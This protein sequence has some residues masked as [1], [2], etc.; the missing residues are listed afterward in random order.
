MLQKPIFFHLGY[1]SRISE[2]ER[3]LEFFSDKDVKKSLNYYFYPI[4]ID[5]EQY[6]E[7]VF[8]AEDILSINH[9]A[10]KIPANIIFLP[11]FRPV[12]AFSE[13]EKEEFNIIIDNFLTAFDQKLD[14]LEVL[15]ETTT[16]MVEN[17]GGIERVGRPEIGSDKLLKKA[18]SY[19]VSRLYEKDEYYSNH[20]FT[21]STSSLRFLLEYIDYTKD[22]TIERFTRSIY[23]RVHNSA[24]I[25][26]ID[27][28][29]FSETKDIYCNIPLYEKSAYNNIQI[30]MLLAESYK[31]MGWKRF[32]IIAEK[33][34]GFLERE[35]KAPDG[36]YYTYS[37][38]STRCEDS[39]YYQFTKRDIHTLFPDSYEKIITSLGMDISLPSNR[40]QIPKNSY[41]AEQLTEDELDL[42]RARRKKNPGMLRDERQFAYI[43]ALVIRSYLV[44]F[45]I[46]GKKEY[47]ET[48]LATRK[49]LRDKFMEG[50]KVFRIRTDSI[51]KVDGGL[52]DY[53]QVIRADID[54]YRTLQKREYLNDAIDI[55][56]YV[57]ENFYKEENGM[58][59]AESKG[60]NLVPYN[61]E[62]NIDGYTPSSN[63]SMCYILLELND[64][65]G[66]KRYLDMAKQQLYN[67]IP[68]IMD[69]APLLGYWMHDILYLLK[70]G[71]YL[72]E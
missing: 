32:K 71:D 18:I 38:L 54:L 52:I 31:H 8:L 5:A 28:G 22:D 4:A 64:I 44:L 72:S 9:I 17:M 69:S 14:T 7:M 56:E 6:P 10:K 2:R 65:T 50:N 42:L 27:G 70:K 33:I 47:L 66:E 20:P 25:D 13:L 41:F 67:I 34:A 23:D 63:A 12:T 40:K 43:N 19:W 21:V 46:T 57:I 51:D 61:R 26:P 24:A 58:F 55:T 29:I 39:T 36:G 3:T 62:H 60:N 48:S 1:V 53:V 16:S 30:A 45:E 35:M 59:R 15:A 37:T 49:L 68:H 11:D